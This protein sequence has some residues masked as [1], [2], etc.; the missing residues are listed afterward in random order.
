MR[1]TDNIVKDI[2]SIESIIQSITVKAEDLHQAAPASEISDKYK[3]LSKQA[4][5]FYQKQKDAL[6]TQQQFI[7]AANVFLQWL[8]TARERLGKISDTTGDKDTLSGRKSQLMVN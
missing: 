6:D 4:Q 1:Q 2:F 5:E 7:D 3:I 8:R